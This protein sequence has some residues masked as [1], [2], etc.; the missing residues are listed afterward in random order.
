MNRNYLIGFAAVL[1]V[2]GLLAF[3][4][5][6]I[7]EIYPDTRYLPPSRE[8]RVNEYLA[9]DR[10]LQ[11]SGIP[12]RTSGSGDLA[13]ILAAKEK[14]IF[15][16]ASLFRWSEEAVDYII[17]WIEEGG[18]LF[19]SL[20]N[21]E[22]IFNS[23]RGFKEPIR[24]LE[25][26]GIKANPAENS[27][28]RYSGFS[29]DSPD[30]DRKVF[31]EAEGDYDYLALKDGGDVIRLVQVEHGRGKLI[32]SGYS[33]FLLTSYIEDAP[34]AR[35]AWALFAGDDPE[36][37][38]FI[39]GSVKVS[40]LLGSLWTQ[41]N[42]SVLLVSLAVLLAIGFWTVIPVFGLVRHDDEK[43]LKPLRERFLA[44]GRFLK[45]YGALDSYCLAYLKEIKRRLIRQEGLMEDD[46][47][48]NRI[49]EAWGKHAGEKDSVLLAGFLRGEPSRDREFTKL[50]VILKSL[51][52][53]I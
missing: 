21:S 43:P 28:T 46:V 30:Y 24:L 48:Q 25:E 32:V 26:F 53:R 34:N 35:L 13:A 49:M 19:L 47:M 39:R 52:E 5:W 6:S 12:V 20:D 40:G 1:A 17:S 42:L 15:I 23:Y 22:A 50:V 2:L 11:G 51:L 36:G 44:E 9:L 38:F 4:L 31:F 16:Q 8:A 3:T 33:R 37:W 27:S 45:R 29:H 41:G 10:W 14:R 7:F 18:V